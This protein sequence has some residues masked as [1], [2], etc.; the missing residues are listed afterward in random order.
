MTVENNWVQSNL[1]ERFTNPSL[2]FAVTLNPNP[3]TIM[4]FHAASDYTA[5]RI[6]ERFPRLF[7]SFSGGADSEY[8]FHCIYRNK[9]PF[10]PIIVKTSGNASELAYAFHCCKKYNIEPVVIELS[11]VDYIEIYKKQVIE[12]LSGCG[13]C[14]VPGIVACRY[15]RDHGGVIIIGEHMIDND[16]TSIW[17]GMNEWDFYNEVFVGEEYTIPFFYYTTDLAYAMIERIENMPIH[18]WKWQLYE[19]L[20]FRPVISYHFDETFTRIQK[21]IFMRRKSRPKY[22][23]ILGTQQTTLDLLLRN[24]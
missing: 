11:D 9:I 24:K 13:L 23:T 5:R 17:P 10:T 21:S 8:V 20:A 3:I 18:E 22:Q 6:Y 16:D 19:Y 14:A 1:Q 15:A 7:L 12:Q 2:D 4:P